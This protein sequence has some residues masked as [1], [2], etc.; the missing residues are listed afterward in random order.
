MGESEFFIRKAI[1]LALREYANTEPERV[2]RFLVTN[3]K[4][5]SGLSY[6]EAGKHLA[7]A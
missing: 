5:L 4:G 3:R 2:R 1:G 6:R 7:G